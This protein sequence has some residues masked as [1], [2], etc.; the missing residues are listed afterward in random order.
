MTF[1]IV[2]DFKAFNLCLDDVKTWCETGSTAAHFVGISAGA[3]LTFHFDEDPGET[4]LSDL[5]SYYAG[6][7]TGSDEAV[8]YY[9]MSEAATALQ[10]A[11]EDA[12]TK[13]YDQLS[14]QQKKIIAGATL[15]AADHRQLITDFGA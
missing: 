11:R 1:D 4:A 9:S 12:A 10:A 13:N 6:L 2:K 15:T 5:D 8:N 14:T 3:Q 7:N